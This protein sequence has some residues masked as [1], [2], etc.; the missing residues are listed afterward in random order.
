MVLKKGTC[1][2]KRAVAGEPS[3]NKENGS[4]AVLALHN[5]HHSHIDRDLR[6]LGKSRMTF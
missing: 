5:S 6:D 3:P 4:C 2:Q 1:Y